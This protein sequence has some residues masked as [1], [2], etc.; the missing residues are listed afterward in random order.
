MFLLS[1]RTSTSK[2]CFEEHELGKAATRQLRSRYTQ[3][4]E[5][6]P[7]AAAGSPYTCPVKLDQQQLPLHTGG[8][9]LS[10]WRYV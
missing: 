10:P 8:R 2:R 3:P 1:A 5:P 7:A 9:S 6:S 4:K